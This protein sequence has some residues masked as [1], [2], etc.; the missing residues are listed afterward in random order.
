[1]VMH[2]VIGDFAIKIK[3]EAIAKSPDHNITQS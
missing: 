1:M 3:E 2:F